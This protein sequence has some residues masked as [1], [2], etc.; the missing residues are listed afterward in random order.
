MFINLIGALTLKPYSF[1][2][3]SWELSKY[4]SIDFFD[5]M[6]SSTELEVRGSKIL[7]VLPCRSSFVED[8]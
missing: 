5:S 2:A 7:R 1:S 6:A 4:V 8:N 3:R